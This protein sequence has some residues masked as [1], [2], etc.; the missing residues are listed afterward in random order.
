MA[1]VRVST[2][3]PEE[4]FRW[5]QHYAATHGRK[6]T[7]VFHEAVA[8]YRRKQEEAEL[9]EQLAEAHREWREDGE[10]EAWEASE[11]DGA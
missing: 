6:S 11:G 4:D 3:L 2:T 9:V 10:Q 7:V 5:M 1:I 8:D